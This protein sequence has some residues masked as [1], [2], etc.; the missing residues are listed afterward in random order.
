MIGYAVTAIITIAAG[1][2]EHRSELALVLG[3]ARQAAARGRW[4]CRA[5]GW[6][7]RLA[8]HRS[9]PE[10]SDFLTWSRRDLTTLGGSMADVGERSFWIASD[11]SE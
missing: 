2:H 1:A 3:A 9:A 11:T 4:R 5:P 7:N 10:V 6:G 8:A